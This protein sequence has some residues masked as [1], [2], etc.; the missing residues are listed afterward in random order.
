MAFVI[1]EPC[2]SKPGEECEKACVE[3][4]PVECIYEPDEIGLPQGERLNMLYI[5]PYECVHC[6][7]CVPV[8][9][10][11]AIFAEEDVPEKW[12]K[13]TE[14]HI[15]A[16]ERGGST[17]L[18]ACPYGLACPHVRAQPF[19]INGTPASRPISK[20]GSWSGWGVGPFDESR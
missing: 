20:R 1:C 3:V 9:S 8:C 18:P 5:H 12:E 17:K 7:A 10:E 14:I 4:C 16:F 2:I 19:Q 15:Q 13:Y 11:Q 6:G